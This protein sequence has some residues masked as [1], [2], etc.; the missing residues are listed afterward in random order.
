MSPINL[1]LNMSTY[2]QGGHYC[3]LRSKEALIHP[4][5]FGAKL[6]APKL[7]T[8]VLIHINQVHSLIIR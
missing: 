7:S 3:L 1:Y 5:Y 2:V 8:H 4:S 6:E